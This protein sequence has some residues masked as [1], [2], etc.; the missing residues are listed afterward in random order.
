[1]YRP[2]NISRKRGGRGEYTTHGEG[3]PSPMATKL[4]MTV[5]VKMIDSQRWICRVHLSK[6]TS[7]V[8]EMKRV[9]RTAARP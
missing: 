7:S 3:V 6:G 1:M 4:A 5:A 2:V 8:D 9:R